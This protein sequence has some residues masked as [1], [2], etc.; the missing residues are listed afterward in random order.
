MRDPE[1][2]QGEKE[3]YNKFLE[4][5]KQSGQFDGTVGAMNLSYNTKA[6][7]QASGQDS[8]ESAREAWEKMIEETQGS[9]LAIR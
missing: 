8:S 4:N 5:L 3:F 7:E 2:I 6:I 9:L 1:F